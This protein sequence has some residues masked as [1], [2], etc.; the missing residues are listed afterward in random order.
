MICGKS[1]KEL[2]EIWFVVLIRAVFLFVLDM[3]YSKPN[4]VVILGQ[5]VYFTEKAIVL[6]SEDPRFKDP[7]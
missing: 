2:N 7:M 5:T 6:N 4:Q 3:A 1:S